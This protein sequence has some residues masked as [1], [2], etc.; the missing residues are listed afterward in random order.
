MQGCGMFK[1]LKQIGILVMYL[2][3]AN[4]LLI[5]LGI[6]QLN[7]QWQNESTQSN[8]YSSNGFSTTAD[9]HGNIYGVGTY[10]GSINFGSLQITSNRPSQNV[11]Y[12]VKLNPAGQPVWGTTPIH[13]GSTISYGYS[14]ACDSMDGVYIVGMYRDSIQF[15]NDILTSGASNFFAYFLVKYDTS[16]NYNWAVNIPINSN[17]F[18]GIPYVDVDHSGNV[19]VCGRYPISINSSSLTVG[20]H[21]ITSNLNAASFLLKVS[22]SGNPLWLKGTDNNENSSSSGVQYNA[23]TIGPNN[24]IY[25]VGYIFGS[26]GFSGL[27]SPTVSLPFSGNLADILIVKYDS[28]VLLC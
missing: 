3:I 22:P 23:L 14:V 15:G 25:V 6:A 28:L 24:E 21:T 19:L 16:G 7:W 17:I 5:T 13:Y 20:I 1:R 18:F 2:F 11:A 10:R 9:I 26:S 8:G 4:T 12:F 27:F